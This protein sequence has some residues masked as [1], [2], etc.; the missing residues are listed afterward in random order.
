MACFAS[1]LVM[2]RFVPSPPPLRADGTQLCARNFWIR[3]LGWEE[4]TKGC[5]GTEGSEPSH[6][7]AQ[8]VFPE[9]GA[10]QSKISGGC[11]GRTALSLPVA[12]RSL[13]TRQPL[14]LASRRGRGADSQ[15]PADGGWGQGPSSVMAGSRHVLR[16]RPLIKEGGAS[17]LGFQSF[18]PDFAE[19]V[20]PWSHRLV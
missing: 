7:E 20:S 5:S 12:P 8:V 1:L 15:A 2:L 3:A 19:T 18:S 16:V 17:L 13:V 4:V 11:S 6:P 10:V 9:A 14:G